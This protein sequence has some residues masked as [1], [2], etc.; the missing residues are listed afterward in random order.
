M[1][2]RFKSS[3]DIFSK[4]LFLTLFFKLHLLKIQQT[5]TFKLALV[6]IVRLSILHAVTNI[7][8]AIKNVV[9]INRFNRM[10]K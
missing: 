10:T 6:L 2:V 1:S 3:A 8:V 9:I 7:Y 4:H 5:D